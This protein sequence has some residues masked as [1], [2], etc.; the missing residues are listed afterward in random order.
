MAL[1][2]GQ[3]Q[4][5]LK[6]VLATRGLVEFSSFFYEVKE[7]S[8]GNEL[9]DEV[10]LR[11]AGH[12]FFEFYDVRMVHEHEDRDFFLQALNH[13]LSFQ[14]LLVDNLHCVDLLRID[15]PSLPHAG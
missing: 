1:A 10:D 4:D 11:V 5:K 7:L 14:G 15:V 2:V 12:Y 8:A 6:E 13:G 9:E 3:G